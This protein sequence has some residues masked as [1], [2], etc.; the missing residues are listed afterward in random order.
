[1]AKVYQAPS[2]I[3][4]PKNDWKLSREERKKNDDNYRQSLKEHLQ[5]RNPNDSNV[6]Q[7]LEFQVGD[8]YA[9][10]M[11]ASTKPAELVHIELGDAWEY[12]LV[13]RM[14]SKDIVN[15]VEQQK[16]FALVFSK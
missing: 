12:H 9:E 14:T 1:M 8:G 13:N 16:R 5:K 6:G 15:Q 2:E 11:V 3:K 4:I 10:Y 7:I